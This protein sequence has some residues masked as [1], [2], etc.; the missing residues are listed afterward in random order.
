MAKH[1]APYPPEFR[2]EAI[3]LARTSG[4]PHAEIA[5]ELGMTDETLR[6][7]LK[8]ADLDEGKRSDGLTSD[9]QEELRRLRR[10]NRILREEREI[11]NKAA[12]H[13]PRRRATRS[14]SRLCVRGTREGAP[15]RRNAL[16]R[17]RCLPERLLGLAQT[18]PVAS[19]TGRRGIERADCRDSPGEPR[20][21]WCAPHPCRTGK[22]G[23]TLRT[24]AHR[25]P[26]ARRWS[27]ELSSSA[28]VPDDVARPG[29]RARPG[30]GPAHVHGER[31]QC[32]LDRRHHVRPDAAGGLPLSGGDPRCVQPARS[33]LVHG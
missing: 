4:K 31:P 21:V 12:A 23:D 17:A 2:A 13:L 15:R 32:A 16:P 9:E 26:H 18:R 1:M 6:L 27:G 24:Q 33:G 8:Q 14:G 30:P 22:R 7:W 25:P 20:H 5:R 10:E 11:L 3:R 28:L 29:S 19:G